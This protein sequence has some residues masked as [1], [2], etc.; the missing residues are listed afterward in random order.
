MKKRTQKEWEEIKILGQIAQKHLLTL[1]AD[2]FV[3]NVYVN[4]VLCSHELNM[5]FAII[6]KGD[7]IDREMLES[8]GYRTLK[9]KD[10]NAPQIEFLIEYIFRA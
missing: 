8:Y 9:A 3:N 6:K 7:E 5:K 2:Q 10:I 1:E 4:Y